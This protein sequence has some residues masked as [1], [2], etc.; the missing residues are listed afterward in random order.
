MASGR[1]VQSRRETN[2]VGDDDEVVMA[3]CRKVK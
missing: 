3:V 1:I 2:E